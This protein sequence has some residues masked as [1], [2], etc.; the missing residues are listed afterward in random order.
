MPTI[1]QKIAELNLGAES[2]ATTASILSRITSGP[3]AVDRV[4]YWLAEQ[5]LYERDATT[6]QITGTIASLIVS[7]QTPVELANGLRTFINHLFRPGS[8]TIATHQAVWSVTA[9]ALL[10]TLGQMEVLSESQIGAFYQLDGGKVFPDGVTEQQVAD[11]KAAQLLDNAL[12]WVNDRNE[13]AM[14]AANAAKRANGATVQ[15]IKDAAIAVWE[16]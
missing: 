7:G 4:L 1:M 2:N 14:E 3:I 5:G 9:H 11:A 8:K 16:S 6:G 13:L 15:S 10:T 12:S